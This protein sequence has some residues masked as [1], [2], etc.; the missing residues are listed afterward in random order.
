MSSLS[1]SDCGTL[2]SEVGAIIPSFP[3]LCH[4]IL[5]AQSAPIND[6]PQTTI[7][8]LLSATAPYNTNLRGCCPIPGCFWACYVG[9]T[10]EQTPFQDIKCL[11]QTTSY[12]HSKTRANSWNSNLSPSLHFSTSSQSCVS[13]YVVTLPTS[14]SCAPN[15]I[16]DDALSAFSGVCCNSSTFN[17]TLCFPWTPCHSGHNSELSPLFSLATFC[18]LLF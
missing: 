11:L 7:Q 17:V 15:E 18:L 8:S 3:L 4:G 1:A 6:T 10:K 14:S 2:S 9:S 12:R 5:G 13:L 16:S